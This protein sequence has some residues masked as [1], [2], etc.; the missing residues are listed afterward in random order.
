MFERA[1]TV[2]HMGSDCG[3]VAGLGVKRDKHTRKIGNSPNN[4]RER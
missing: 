3:Q 4:A 1:A 2:M